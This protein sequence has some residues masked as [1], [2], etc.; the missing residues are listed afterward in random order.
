MS[1]LRG[2]V[3]FVVSY[4]KVSKRPKVK[5]KRKFVG[6]RKLFRN[7]GGMFLSAVEDIAYETESEIVDAGKTKV[8]HWAVNVDDPWG[9]NPQA[10]MVATRLPEKPACGMHYEIVMLD[11][12]LEFPEEPV[13]GAASRPPN[14]EDA[15]TR[16]R[17]ALERDGHYD[18]E[19]GM[20]PA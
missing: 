6:F 15:L 10:T 7:V 14:H 1:T 5:H 2:T 4:R 13:N 18:V 17:A 12:S 9:I 11:E 20:P 19:A 3:P 8:V 16:M